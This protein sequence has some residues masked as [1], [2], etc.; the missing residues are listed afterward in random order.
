MYFYLHISKKIRTFAAKFNKNLIIMYKVFL[1]IAIAASV[2]FVIQLIMT[3][4]GLGGDADVDLDNADGLD[5]DTVGIFTF[6]NLV[7]FL[8]G[9]GW[10]GIC[11]WNTIESTVWLQLTAVGVGLI[12]FFGFWILLKQILRL[13][14]NSTFHPK[15]AIGLSADVYLHIPLNGR[16]KVQFSYRGSVH[17]LDAICDTD[18]PTGAKCK[19]VGNKG[20]LLIVEKI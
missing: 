3:L 7:N 10:G 9:Y 6:K 12:F 20:D 4:I 16:G 19:I 2:V 18:L 15:Q 11:F 1:Y 8:L 13:S 5:S 17:E 14:Q